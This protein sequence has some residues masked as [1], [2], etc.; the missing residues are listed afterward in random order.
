[1]TDRPRRTRFAPSLTGRLH[2]GHVA[3]LLWVFG[4]A[5]RFGA[6]VLLRIED[7][8]RSR[9]RA[10]HERAI[11][12]DVDRLGFRFDRDVGRQSEDDAPYLAALERLRAAARVYGCACTRR[13]IAAHS[14]LSR[15]GER[16]YSGRC[17]DRGLPPEPP[18][19]ARVSLP[20]ETIGFEDLLMGEQLQ[21]AP[22]A[23]TG[24][25]LLRDRQGQWSYDFSVV[26][27]DLRQGVDLVVR[28]E[29]LLHATQ[30]Q[31]VLGRM[32]GREAT[33]FLAHHP[34][35]VDDD[36]RKLSKRDGDAAISSRL[37]RGEDPEAVIGEAAFRG[38]I[39]ERAGSLSL[40]QAIDYAAGRLR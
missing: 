37:A 5:R 36:G 39:A 33:P 12:S 29:D 24:D 6:D 14:E 8:D 17:R 32:L 19:A 25:L 28:G 15:S 21:D 34:L 26:V 20:A 7:H 11:R 40:D 30:R 31:A 18:Y 2:L 22:P 35:V 13:E 9:A 1:M 4:A 27:D 3:H 16:L 23:G 10:E 38:G